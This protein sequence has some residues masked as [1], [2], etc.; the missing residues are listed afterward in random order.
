MAPG[1]G[2][3]EWPTLVVGPIALTIEADVF[4]APWIDELLGECRRDPGPRAVLRHRLKVRLERT[5]APRDELPR[6]PAFTFD[7]ARWIDHSAGWDA[8]L[9][10]GPDATDAT[11]ALREVMPAGPVGDPYRRQWVASALRVALAMAAPACGGLLLHGAALVAARGV[12]FLGPS[13]AGKTSMSA[14]LPTWRPLA[15]DAILV[16]PRRD[17]EGCWLLVGTP[18]PGRERY[19][20]D[21][22]PAD[23][24]ALVHLVPNAA[25]SLA[26]LSAPEAFAALLPRIL[27]FAAPSDAVLAAADALVG[28][29]SSHRLASRLDDD[30]GPTLAAVDAS[31]NRPENARC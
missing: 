5:S 19:P 7:G 8:T 24:G 4:F 10:F 18:A 11:F 23:L 14:R 2:V 26:R 27:W 22:R 21:L 12:A 3:S 30:L 13:G 6:T 31:T 9:A 16:S 25:L 20:R 15:D 17:P 1:L 28:A 29:V